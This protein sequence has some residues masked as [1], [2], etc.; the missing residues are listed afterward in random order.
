[1]F[2]GAQI[3]LIMPTADTELIRKFAGKPEIVA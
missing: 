3:V 1:M 2:S